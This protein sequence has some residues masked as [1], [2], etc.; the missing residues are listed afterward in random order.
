M[1]HDGDNGQQTVSLGDGAAGVHEEF[2]RSLS[3][4]EESS[5]ELI[6]KVA[7]LAAVGEKLSVDGDRLAAATR[8]LQAAVGQLSDRVGSVESL[9]REQHRETMDALAQLG[10]RFRTE[11]EL[12]LVQRGGGGSDR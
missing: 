12:M 3:A 8:Q 1:D 2:H 10:A 6:D 11:R 5:L 4:L 7:A 9:M